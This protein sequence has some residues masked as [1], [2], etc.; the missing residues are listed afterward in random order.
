[1][2][3]EEKKF[4]ENASDIEKKIIKKNE[5]FEKIKKNKYSEEDFKWW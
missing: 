3:P 1:M 5:N 4:M 2:H